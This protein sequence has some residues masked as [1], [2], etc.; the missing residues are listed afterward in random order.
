MYTEIECLQI[1]KTNLKKNNK[2]GRLILPG[3]K[4]CNKSIVIKMVWRGHKDRHMDLWNRIYS[5]IIIKKNAKDHSMEKE[6]S[7]H[8]HLSF[9]GLP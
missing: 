8:H 3:F 4:T 2:A 5:Q 7:L 1:A 6:E 9:L